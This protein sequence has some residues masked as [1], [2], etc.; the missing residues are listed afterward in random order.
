MVFC[1]ASAL[2]IAITMRPRRD[3]LPPLEK[4]R[5][6]HNWRYT[7]ESALSATT[8][9]LERQRPGKG[10]R[11][12]LSKSDIE[13]FIALLPD[14]DELADGLEAIVLLAGNREY[15]GYYGPGWV[16]ICAWERALWHAYDRSCLEQPRESIVR[17][18]VPVEPLQ[19]DGVIAKWTEDTVRAYQLLDVMLHELGHHRDRMSTRSRREPSRGESFAESYAARYAE[20][21][22][23]AYVAEFG[24]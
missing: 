17:L 8:V 23:D 9:V 6:T 16:G 3:R 2:P 18:G 10:Y 22:W 15:Q 20:Q 19:E 1:L 24:W 12:I 7:P 5:K 13:R 11:H 4:G 14:W 21:I